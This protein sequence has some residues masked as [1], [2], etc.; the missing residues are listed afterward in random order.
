MTQAE[1]KE[2]LRAA[3]TKFL[4]E[5]EYDA[6]KMKGDLS[7]GQIAE[8]AMDFFDRIMEADYEDED[9]GDDD[10]EEDDEDDDVDDDEEDDEE[11]G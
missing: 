4:D 3:F 8:Y 11:E 1:G 5:G 6:I 10:D 7:E 2:F 9:G